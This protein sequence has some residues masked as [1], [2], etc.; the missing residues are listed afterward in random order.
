[1][2]A[3]LLYQY[4]W[5]GEKEEADTGA[6]REHKGEFVEGLLVEYVR[7]SWKRDTFTNIC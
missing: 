3:V 2:L 6:G 1:M 7:K 4:Y 5:P